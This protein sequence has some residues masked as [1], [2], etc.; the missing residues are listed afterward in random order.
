MN[1]QSLA[2]FILLVGVPGMDGWRGGVSD[3][4]WWVML[5]AVVL[6]VLSGWSYLRETPRILAITSKRDQ[7]L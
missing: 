3:L 5:V 2:V 1:A 4:G 7:R 6:T